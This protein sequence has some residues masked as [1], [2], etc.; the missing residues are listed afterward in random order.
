MKINERL[1]QLG[2]VVPSSS[3]PLDIGCDHA[4]LS[5]YLVV[6][7]NFPKVIA[8]DNKEG[9]L[10]CAKENL[11]RYQVERQIQLV[12]ADGL[13]AYQRGVNAVIMSGMGGFMM[14]KILKNHLSLL[15]QIEWLILS[16]N[17]F[18]TQVRTQ[19]NQ[20]GYIIEEELVVKEKH[21]FYPIL[22]CRRGKKHYSKKDLFLGPILKTKKIPLVQEFYQRELSSR[23]RLLQLV[24]VRNFHKWYQT[25][26]EIKWLKQY[27]SL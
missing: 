20:F 25:K 14:I 11:H 22:L 10:Q 23:Y 8:S 12:L 18:T 21:L 16:P 19:V 4:L 2:E 3:Y 26:R 15:E 17:N 6:E 9:P 5:I 27:L 24:S 1:K 7:R 13:A